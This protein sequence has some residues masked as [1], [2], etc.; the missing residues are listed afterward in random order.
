MRKRLSSGH[1]VPRSTYILRMSI[2]E[3]DSSTRR[4]EVFRGCD[5]ALHFLDQWLKVTVKDKGNFS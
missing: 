2:F 3:T 4:D 5:E 1:L